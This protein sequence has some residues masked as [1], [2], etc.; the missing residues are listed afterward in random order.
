M[1]AC[2]C[3]CVCLRK[4]KGEKESLSELDKKKPIHCELGM[5]Y[6]SIQYMYCDR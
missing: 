5:Q 3:V 2:E 4:R 1:F 6:C